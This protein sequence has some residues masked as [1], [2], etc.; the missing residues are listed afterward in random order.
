M[1]ASDV[2]TTDIVSVGPDASETEIAKLMLARGISGVPVVDGSGAALGMVSEGDLIGRD[3]AAR[4]A[5]KDWWL[6]LLA[7]GEAL[8]PEFLTQVR[9]AKR[10]AREIMSTPLVSVTEG[11]ECAE[12]ARLLGTY[13]IKRV[14]VLRDGK[15]CGI[16]SRADLL[17]A[18]ASEAGVG[19]SVETP[20]TST[21]LFAA[22]DRRFL[23]I[24]G[25]AV[26]PAPKN[27][28]RG[29]A[30]QGFTVDD[31]RHLVG[32]FKH[33]QVERRQEAQHEE[34]AHRHELVEELI[35]KHIADRDWQ[36]LLHEARVAAEHGAKEFMLLRFPSELCS[37]HGRA[38][39]LP[40]EGWP[41]TLRGEAAEI[42]LRWQRDLH[43]RGFRL[44]ARVLDFPGGFPGDIGLF[45]IWDE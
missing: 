26:A 41:E 22:I 39:N 25:D 11:T 33:G 7:E 8:S 45:L 30:G 43:P 36:A 2:M 17:R 32:G 21:G 34:V 44:A 28:I 20:P 35:D 24:R 14:P 10:R 31:F 9:S 23:H 4:E 16:V 29:G 40:E 42:Y 37:D 13:R 15:I 38:I 1:K 12:I 18:L 3:D 19:V 5:R 27:P 6:N